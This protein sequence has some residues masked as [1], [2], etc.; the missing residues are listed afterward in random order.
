MAGEDRQDSGRGGLIVAARPD[1]LFAGSTGLIGQLVL[2]LLLERSSTSRS[3]IFT[4]VRSAMTTAHPALVPVVGDPAQ[5][6]SD[7]R[8]EAA[9]AAH[10]AALGVFVCTLG[11]TLA[12]AGSQAAFAAVD[13]DLVLHLAALAHRH[14]ASHCIVV[15]SVGADAR[16]SNFYLRTKGRMERD[17]SGLGF[18]RCDFLHPGLLLGARDGA[19]RPGE[20]IAQKLSPFYNPLLAG[21]LR[22]YRAIPAATVARAIAGLTQTD[23]DGI[24]RH[25]YDAMT[26]LAG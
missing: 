5:A 9:L 15:S 22:R 25:E 4:P 11:T 17:L 18:A 21:P 8:I 24:F 23:G 26:A 7:A 2:P 16:A 13:R 14:G 6:A 19:N 3:R 12:Q 1:I 20:S 10:D